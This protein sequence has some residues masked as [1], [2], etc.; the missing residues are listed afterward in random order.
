MFAQTV[1]SSAAI[2]ASASFFVPHFDCSFRGGFLLFCPDLHPKYP[3]CL[4][5]S[6][7]SLQHIACSFF[8]NVYFWMITI[9]GRGGVSWLQDGREMSGRTRRRMALWRIIV[10]KY[11]LQGSTN[12]GMTFLANSQVPLFQNT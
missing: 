7:T 6:S 1:F 10:W 3:G 5:C 2:T 9:L 11:G 12:Q 4:F 8:S